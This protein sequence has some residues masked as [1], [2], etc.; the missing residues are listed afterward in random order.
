MSQLN[1]PP[2]E[3]ILGHFRQ[4]RR[5]R[6]RFLE[7]IRPYGDIVPLRLLN[8]P[9]FVLNHPDYVYQVLVQDADHFIKSPILRRALEP[10]IGD[11]LL[12]SEG[13]FHRRQRRL[14]QPAFHHQRIAAYGDIMVR[15]TL[16]MLEAWGEEQT[17][18]IADEMMRLTMQ[19]VAM[20]LF[21]ADVR[22]EANTIGEAISVA[23]ELGT[24]RG[25]GLHLPLWIP[26]PFNR[27]LKQQQQRLNDMI[28]RIIAERRQSGEDTG[29][30]LSM[31]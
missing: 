4:F 9:V 25:S 15:Y 10:L 20:A 11:G 24:Q 14:I 3:P 19:I 2:A 12:L 18:N 5:D 26:T 13:D 30:L 29:D 28:F 8:K 23:I 1:A 7:A 27:K 22:E 6:R 21:N 16:Q 31:L 17:T